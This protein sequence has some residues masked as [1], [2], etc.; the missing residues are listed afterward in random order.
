MG[1]RLICKLVCTKA[2]TSANRTPASYTSSQDNPRDHPNNWQEFIKKGMEWQ[3]AIMAIF[4]YT[5]ETFKRTS[6]DNMGNTVCSAFAD[7]TLKPQARRRLQ[8]SLPQRFCRNPAESSSP[9]L[10]LLKP[11]LLVPLCPA[12]SLPSTPTA[13]IPPAPLLT[14]M[15]DASPSILQVFLTSNR[16]RSHAE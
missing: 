2:T 4:S 5:K 1:Y 16:K 3:I 10:R 6:R 12:Q 11:T 14:L 15:R 9:L 7:W 13:F 8:E